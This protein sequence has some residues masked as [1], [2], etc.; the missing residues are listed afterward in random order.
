[1]GVKAVKTS[2]AVQVNALPGEVAGSG[3]DTLGFLADQVVLKEHLGPAE[4]LVAD[5]DV[6]ILQLEEFGIM[7]HFLQENVHQKEEQ[8]EKHP[9]A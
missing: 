6:I 1:M 7:G 9:S 8:H 4:A 5:C 3:V 2:V